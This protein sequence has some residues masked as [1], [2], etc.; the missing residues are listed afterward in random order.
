[1][2]DDFAARILTDYGAVC[3]PNPDPEL[4]AVRTAVLIED[5]FDVVLSDAEIDPGLLGSASGVVA[6]VN[7][8]REPN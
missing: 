3:Q 2:N 1:V 7:R 4:E 5:V 8:H 6:M